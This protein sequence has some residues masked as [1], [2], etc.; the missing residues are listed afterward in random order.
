MP[1]WEFTI[2]GPPV[3]KGRPRASVRGGKYVKMYTP[4]K[5]AVWEAQA[6]VLLRDAWD[7]PM[8]EKPCRLAVEAVFPRPQRLIWKRKPMP[9]EPHTSKPDTDNLVKAVCDAVEKASIVRNDS[10]IYKV[11]A[12]KHIASGDESPHVRVVILWE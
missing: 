9:R 6:S 8:L 12:T 3:A 11:L 10:L 4:H 2:P 7:L 1:R 5:T